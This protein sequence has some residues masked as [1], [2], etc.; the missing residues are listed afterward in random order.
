MP[1]KRITEVLARWRGLRSNRSLWDQHW[2]DLA[3]VQ[4]PRRLGFV[5]AVIEGDRRT[6][7]LYDG[8]AIQA[9]RGLANQFGGK[10]RPEGK[11]WFFLK[12]AEDADMRDDE[13]KEWLADTEQRL[14]DAFDN[15]VARFRQAS[16]EADHD[17]VVFG[18][19]VMGIF[20]QVGQKEKAET[21]YKRALEITKEDPQQLAIA[22]IAYAGMLLREKRLDDALDVA[23]KAY[24]TKDLKTETKTAARRML[25]NVY[26]ARGE[27][28]KMEFK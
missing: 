3:R 22:Q 16:G 10:M 20:E 23:K 15:P 14:R 9:S 21:A 26:E 27:A 13:A 5:T 18:T 7:D 24:E 17:L 12:T 19:A 1:E 25:F 8:T 2:E 4:L 28:E 11:P 6:E